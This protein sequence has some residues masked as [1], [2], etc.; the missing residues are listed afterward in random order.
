MKKL[1]STMMMLV[2]FAT[3]TIAE[4]VKLDVS[5]AHP[6]LKADQ[7]QTTYLK[8]SLA[9]F[10]MEKATERSAV[11]VAI[12]IDR[13]GSMQ[14]DK[15]AK[16]REAAIMA[17]KRLDEKDIVSIVTYDTTVNV[18]V[19]ATKMTNRDDVISKIKQIKT[20][21]S[22]ALFAGVSKAAEEVRKFFDKNKVNR[23]ILISDG[24][25]NIGPSSPAQLGELGLS[26]GREGIPVTTIGLGL[27][28]NEDL[29]VQLAGKSDGNHSFAKDAEQLMAIFNREFSDV[30]SVVAQEVAVRI[31][32]ADG[33]RPIR[34]LGREV[35]I[36]GQQVTTTLN[37]LYSE[38]EKYIMLEVEIA[39]GKADAVK[40]IASV[41]VSYANMQTRTNDK[42]VSS[43]SGR[44]TKDLEKVTKAVNK[45]VMVEAVAQIAILNNEVAIKLRDL[46]K[47]KEATDQ[48]IFN[49]KFIYDNNKLLQSESLKDMEAG[50]RED[51]INLSPDKWSGGGRKAMRSRNYEVQNQQKVEPQKEEPKK[52]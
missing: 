3:V 2:L 5:L 4:Q 14:G 11:N 46:G 32:C 41:D 35:E 24:L 21:G 47:L 6:F 20:G 40:A 48:L 29:M 50:N 26:L 31:Q 19:P 51:I 39:A 27:G 43:I 28:Y 45:P 25:A 7:K 30:L 52:K 13:S 22:T 36:N 38:Q 17:L 12:V 10:K 34:V 33:V 16:A 49:G 15:I 37:Q 18:L 1:C 9:G 42:L 23:I 8:V 44:F